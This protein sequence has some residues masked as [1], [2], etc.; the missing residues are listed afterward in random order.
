MNVYKFHFLN[1][2]S[3]I[4][5]FF[6]DILIIWPAPW[7]Y[8]IQSTWLALWLSLLSTCSWCVVSVLAPLSC[9]SRSIIQVDAAHWWWLRRDPPHMI[10]KRFGCTTIHKKRYINASF[11]HSFI[12]S[13][14]YIYF[15]FFYVFFYFLLVNSSTVTQGFICVSTFPLF[16]VFIEHYINNKTFGNTLG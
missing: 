4:N 9:G 15:Y 6:D 16:F 1:G 10:V 13:P 8:L 7:L 2:I 11:I 3:E 14:V 12:H 5:Q